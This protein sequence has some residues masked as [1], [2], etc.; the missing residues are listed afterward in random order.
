[1]AVCAGTIV[2]SDAA[3]PG[4]AASVFSDALDGV[5]GAHGAENGSLAA[6]KF[7]VLYRWAPRFASWMHARRL[8]HPLVVDF[9]VPVLRKVR[10]RHRITLGARF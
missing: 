1:M 10:C 3:G 4:I 2:V 8:M 6:L 9:M 7:H 5:K